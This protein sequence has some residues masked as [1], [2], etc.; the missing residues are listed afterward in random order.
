MLGRAAMTNCSTPTETN[1]PA[2]LP[3]IPERSALQ[4]LNVLTGQPQLEAIWL[5]GSR[6]MGRHQPGSDIDLCLE[7]PRLGHSDLL[8]LMNAVDDLCLPWRVDLLLLH[9]LDAEMRAH[10]QRAGRSLWKRR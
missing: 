2:A 6:A 10:V 9:Q 3:G 5:F 7:A 4:L 8:R 1:S